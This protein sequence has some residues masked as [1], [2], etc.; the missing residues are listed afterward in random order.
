MVKN[1]PLVTIGIPAYNRAVLLKR[2]IESALNQ[3]Y[4]NIEVIVSD[5]AS[6]DETESICRHFCNMDDRLKYIRQSSNRGAKANFNEVLDKASG[7]FFMW[8]GDDDWIDPN[9]ISSCVQQLISDPAIVLVSGSP[10]YYR[11]VEKVYGG[12]VFS[13]LHDIWWHR[14]ISYY[15]N[16]ADNGMF[17]GVMPTALIRNIEIP[18]TMGGDWVMLANIIS[19]GK[20]KM[21][22]EISVHRELG[23][24]SESFENIASINGLPK[25][26]AMFP[27]LFTACSA[28]SDIM[29]KELK[30]KQLPV[31]TKIFVVGAVF[32]I[33]ISK[34][35]IGLFVGVF[36]R[37]KKILNVA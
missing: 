5:N 37:L 11:S 18:H 21:I 14:V 12:K 3:D 16:V 9:Y 20:A 15:R 4:D 27:Y 34:R 17:Y 8:L 36:K 31:Y 6:I 23:G 30:F 22:S 29:S 19:I 33:V 32:F 13:L 10:H 7:Q 25:I 26:Q 2:A 35:R 28:C 1:M 24:M